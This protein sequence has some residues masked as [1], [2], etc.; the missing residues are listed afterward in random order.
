MA[1]EA[2]EKMFSA[3]LAQQTVRESVANSSLSSGVSLLQK[4]KYKEAVSSFQQSIAMK[5]DQVDAYNLMASA[6]LQ[7]DDKKKATEAYKMSLRVDR[8][9]VDPRINLANIYIDDK[10]YR[11]AESQL[12]AAILNDPANTLA[13]Y[14]LGNMYIQTDRL[15]EAETELKTV[16]RLSPRDANGYYSLG[17]TYNKL[18]DYGNAVTQLTKATS[19]KQ[20]FALAIYQLGLAY[21][22]LDKKDLAQDQL[23]TLKGIKTSQA[24]DLADQLSLSLATPKIFSFNKANSSFIPTFGPATPLYMLDMS[25]LNAPNASK[26]LTMQFQFDSTM[27]VA[28][29]TNIANWS[30]RRAANATTGSYVAS[31]NDAIVAPLPKSVMYDPTTKQAT[32]TFTISQN[33]S[34][35]GTIDPSHLV[36]KFS[37]KDINGK[38]ID[39]SADEFAGIINEPF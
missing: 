20:D 32:L 13:H 19:M 27:D 10:N 6:Y 2:A 34:G 26:D 37:G 31:N 17:V 33:S 4:K 36:F 35:T 23:T 5:P 15:R 7:L 24:V 11:E 22:G 25:F 29:V 39:S 14:T 28:S 38:L 1:V 12:K 21:N 18:G 3:L 16:T 9:Q 30:I 8:T